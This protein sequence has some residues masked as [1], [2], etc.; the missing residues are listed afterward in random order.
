LLFITGLFR[1]NASDGIIYPAKSLRGGA[2]EIN[3]VV[4]ARDGG[5][6]TGTTKVNITIEDVNEHKPQFLIPHPK[7]SSVV[8]REASSSSV[9]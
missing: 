4:E 7:N 2:R 5:G 6:R 3:L 9:V 8:I 1:I